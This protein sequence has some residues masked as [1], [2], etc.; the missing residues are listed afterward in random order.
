MWAR[1]IIAAQADVGEAAGE[2]TLALGDAGAMPNRCPRCQGERIVEQ[3]WTVETE[4]RRP[5]GSN[6]PM[7]LVTIACTCHDCGTKFR[8]LRWRL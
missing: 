2:D 8:L 6:I 4:G 7:T 5:S 1:W 3:G